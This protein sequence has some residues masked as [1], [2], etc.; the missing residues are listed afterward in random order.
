MARFQD[1][2]IFHGSTFCKS[3]KL[4]KPFIMVQHLY[5]KVQSM[6]Y[7]P[8]VIINRA[9]KC[10]YCDFWHW[11]WRNFLSRRQRSFPKL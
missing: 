2:N 7:T 10:N 8:K 3:S 6:R 5:L 1:V 4:D 9:F 11:S